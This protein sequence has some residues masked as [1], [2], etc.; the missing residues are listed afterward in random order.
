MSQQE[1]EQIRQQPGDFDIPP[2]ASEQN[3]MTIL[4]YL[5]FMMRADGVVMKEEEEFCHHIGFRL[6]IRRDL[7]SDMINLM[8]ECLRQEIPPNAMLERIKPYLN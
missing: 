7:I 1:I 4:Y 2:P 6:G 5:L 8:K 3:R